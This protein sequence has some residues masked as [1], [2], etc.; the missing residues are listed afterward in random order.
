MD[1]RKIGELIYNLR[2]EKNLTQKQISDKMSI[3]DKT[4]SKWERGQGCPDIALLPELS[5]ILGIS[6]DSLL[7]GEINVNEPVGGN[8]NKIK[9][10]VCPQCENLMTSTS[11]AVISC[12]TKKVEALNLKKQDDEHMLDIEKVEDELYV[13]TTHEMKKEHYISF[14]AYV[15]GDQALIV[16][17][18]PEWNMQFRFRKQGRGRLYYYCTND[19][20]F[21][22]TI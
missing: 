12:C 19:G 15:R 1:S 17:Q 3:S 5:E 16:K 11:D 4:I 6:I 13:T 20:L 21:Y 10:Y 7:S 8:M 14:I 9:F 2:K 18:Y 22:Q